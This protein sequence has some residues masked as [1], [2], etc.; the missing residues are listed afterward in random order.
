MSRWSIEEIQE[1]IDEHQRE[2]QCRRN[3][4]TVKPHAF[5]LSTAKVRSSEEVV[6]GEITAINSAA[7]ISSSHPGVVKTVPSNSDA[8]EHVLSIL[9]RTSQPD[10]SSSGS[11]QTH[12]ARFSSCRVC[13][14]SAHS[15][16]LTLHARETVSHLHEGWTPA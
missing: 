9:E 12:R 2:S 16:P 5:Q 8:L 15:T 13:G 3:H 4:S 10:H 1:A 6:G 11:F 7:Y 14:D